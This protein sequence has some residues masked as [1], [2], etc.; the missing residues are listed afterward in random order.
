MDEGGPA[1]NAGEAGGEDLG[2]PDPAFPVGSKHEA[3]EWSRLPALE[4]ADWY[5]L[6]AQRLLGRWRREG[7]SGVS[8]PRK[9]LAQRILGSQAGRGREEAV[10]EPL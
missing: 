2:S 3:E 9:R 5:P 7:R 10:D 1:Q 8:E 6:C 4:F